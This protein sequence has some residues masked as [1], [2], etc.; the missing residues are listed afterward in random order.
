M[1]SYENKPGEQDASPGMSSEE[2]SVGGDDVSVI[3]IDTTPSP[4][5]TE[6]QE[7][8]SVTFAREEEV[9][10]PTV[11]RRERLWTA[12]AFLPVIIL[13]AVLRFWQLGERP[14]HHDE[15][16]H[17]YF[18]LQLL[19]NN[20][21][22][23]ALCLNPATN[24]ACYRYDPLL[25]G[26]FQFHA[27]AIVYAI[28]Q[29]L[30]APDH[31][32]NTTTVRIAA[33]LAGIAIVGLPFFIRDYIGKVG[34]WL[35][36][37]LL[38]VSPSMVYYSRFAREDIYMACFTLLLVVAVARYMRTRK[39]S[40][41]ITVAVAFTLAYATKEATFLVI[42]VFGSFLGALIVWELG[43]RW[44]WRQETDEH[45]S[46]FVPKT[47]AALLVLVYFIVVG[48]IAKVLLGQL[49]QISIKLNDSTT[50]LNAATAYVNHLK[51][52]T[53][54]VIPWLGILL[55][56]VVIVILLREQ[57]GRNPVDPQQ[58]R[59]LA[60]FVNPQKQ[61][62]LDTIVTMPW[63]HWFFGLVIGWFIF[64]ILFTALFTN[65]P[66][67]I[68]DG[69]WQGLF[70]WIQQQQVARGGQPWYYYLLLIPLYEQ[71]GVV[72]SGGCRALFVAPGPFSP[73]HCILVCRQPVH[74]LVGGRKDALADDPYRDPDADSSGDR[75][76]AS[77]Y[78]NT[79]LCAK[80]SIPALR[81]SGACSGN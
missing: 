22:N 12:L 2:M 35:A 76:G 20:I 13:G 53:E 42:A 61:P 59:G 19:H 54:G 39:T 17:G 36:C 28:S 27:I 24:G 46:R 15:S 37:F 56:I 75:F 40:W 4:T 79:E 23:W 71:I 26:P 34:A 38:A 78:C 66:G 25:H 52:V 14:L 47:G 41:F 68:G 73:V 11:S 29:A 45:S 74:L 50:Y 80:S 49:S 64:L 67:G 44:R 32:V 43:Q 9:Q 65:I 10:A 18:S 55:A 31:G 16:L 69:I 60:R 8:D 81:A 1:K 51:T 30:G 3:S 58:R 21:E 77:G 72:W 70:Y 7:T 48:V 63:T 62:V 33:A 5:E 57:F 6:Q